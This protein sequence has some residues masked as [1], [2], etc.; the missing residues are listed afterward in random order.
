MPVAK[1]KSQLAERQELG[2]G[3]LFLKFELVDPHRIDF[4]AGQYLMVDCPLIPQKRQYSI[5]SA[6]RL[7]HGVE[8]LVEVIPNGVVSNYL[9]ALKTGDTLDFY[10]PAGEFVV[11]EEVRNSDVPL[12][13]I[14]TGSGLAPLRSQILDLLRSQETKRPIKLHWGMRHAQDLFWLD[15]WEELAANYPNFTYDIVLSQPPE[16]WQLCRGHV[17]DCLSLHALPEGAHYY[18]CGSQKMT[19]DVLKVLSERG[20]DQSHLHHEKF[21]V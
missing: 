16:G 4:K 5:V 2:Q 14:G 17:T 7:D 18:I 6:P 13:F 1:Y 10:A 19:V 9:A 11:S 3:Y 21:T 20:V 15:Y 12:V 8:L